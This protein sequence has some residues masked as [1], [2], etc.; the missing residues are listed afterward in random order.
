GAA[1][2]DGGAPPHPRQEAVHRP[3]P[4]VADHAIVEATR[5]SR[6][7]EHRGAGEVPLRIVEDEASAVVT[8]LVE[9]SPENGRDHHTS[10][11][12]GRI[13][14]MKRCMRERCSSRLRRGASST[15]W[16]TPTPA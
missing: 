11:V 16:P 4:M 10:S 3:P 2:L 9:P 1:A 14:S 13:S 5:L 6:L 12:K 15:M 8:R 7:H